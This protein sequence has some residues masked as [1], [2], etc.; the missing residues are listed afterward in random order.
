MVW[1]HVIIWEIPSIVLQWRNDLWFKGYAFYTLQVCRKIFDSKASHSSTLLIGPNFVCLFHQVLYFIRRLKLENSTSRAEEEGII[2]CSLA[3]TT[4]I[5]QPS[6]GFDFFARDCLRPL[7]ILAWI[8]ICCPWWKMSLQLVWTVWSF[9]ENGGSV[10]SW[11]YSSIVVILFLVFGKW[12][13]FTPEKSLYFSDRKRKW[14]CKV[15]K[16]K[17]MQ[18]QNKANYFL[19][20][21]LLRNP[22]IPLHNSFCGY[23]KIGKKLEN[24]REKGT[25]NRRIFMRKIGFNFLSKV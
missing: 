7:I 1:F 21:K 25:R 4:E 2:G 15:G 17:T 12:R 8:V 11:L 16:L 3:I 19:W 14:H 23:F 5:D 22:L 13:Q 6:I 9:K 10:C 24:I 20:R 18:Y